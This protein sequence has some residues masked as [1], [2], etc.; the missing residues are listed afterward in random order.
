MKIL[1][2]FLSRLPLSLLGVATLVHDR[3]LQGLSQD[4]GLDEHNSLAVQS[5][6]EAN[7]T[8]V[9]LE[10]RD[11]TCG[12]LNGQLV[13]VTRD[14]RHII[15][16]IKKADPDILIRPRDFYN[17]RASSGRQKLRDNILLEF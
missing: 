3:S 11:L 10:G 4:V 12:P 6:N 8:L 14:T 1:R 2:I 9:H 15:G 7:N 5:A 16:L 13:R 17:Q